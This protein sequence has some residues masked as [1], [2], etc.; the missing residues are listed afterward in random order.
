MAGYWI[1][2]MATA[3][4]AALT[5]AALVP[6]ARKL[7]Y[8]F[9][10]I[11]HP[12]P[13][14]AHSVV[15]PYLGGLAI[16][17]IAVLASLFLPQWKAEAVVIVCAAMIVAAVGLVDDIRS[18]SPLPRLVVEV[19]AASAV[20]AVGARVQLF[21][22][23]ADYLLTVGWLVVLTNSFNLLDNMDGCAGLIAV[24]MASGLAIAA[25]LEDQVLVGG[26]AA[27]VAGACLGFL[28]ANWHPASIFMGDTGSLFLGFILGT[29]SL[30]L[31]FP[32]GHG[33]S[34]SALLLLSGPVLFDTTL[35]VLS[36]VRAHRP[37]Y[38]GGTDHTSHRLLR[39][40]V[41]VPAVAALLATSVAMSV[42]LGV[43]VGS[44]ALPAAP[45]LGGMLMLAAALL[46]LLLRVPV[47]ED[48]TRE[49][50]VF[51]SAAAA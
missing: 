16:A 4:I 9:R 48:S 36:R 31:R 24:V 37:I 46:T 27:V 15:T 39:L 8:R 18:L 25:G 21:G 49:K 6:V 5:T 40:G 29:I 44:G 28:P 50:Q 1:R 41:P 45:V 20:Y 42:G 33:E 23:P 38:I 34:I 10:I 2:I 32:V 47:A 22:G 26:L 43:A 35:V 30:K 17:P 13:G 7:A 3:G 19:V 51:P 11:D 14:K 12:R